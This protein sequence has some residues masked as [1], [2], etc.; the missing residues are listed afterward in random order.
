M[1]ERLKNYFGAVIVVIL[2]IPIILF[3]DAIPTVSVFISFGFSVIL[4]VVLF[5]FK[6]LYKKNKAKEEE[7][8]D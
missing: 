2:F 6:L 4:C 3:I 5:E 7:E 1:T 8:N